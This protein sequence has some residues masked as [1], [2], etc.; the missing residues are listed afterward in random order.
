MLLSGAESPYF[1]LTDDNSIKIGDT[2]IVP[3]GYSGKETEGT[4]VSVGQ[5][6]RVCV[7]FP[8]EKTKKIIR[9]KNG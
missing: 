5:Y 8:V 4:V 2:V 7:P 1:Y 3:V 9:K 6:L